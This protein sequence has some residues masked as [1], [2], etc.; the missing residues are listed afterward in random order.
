[1]RPL[2]FS[3]LKCHA[4]VGIVI[5]IVI[6]SGI[7]I[8]WLVLAFVRYIFIV[9]IKYHILSFFYVGKN[10][11][12]NRSNRKNSLAKQLGEKAKQILQILQIETRRT[13]A[14][15]SDPDP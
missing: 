7:G 13:Q 8:G 1:M 6:V 14:L 12:S 11:K 5:V 2:D 4:V 9:F 15:D 3:S 10:Q